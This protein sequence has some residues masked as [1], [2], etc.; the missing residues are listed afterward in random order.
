MLSAAATC[1]AIERSVDQC[2]R[3]SEFKRL[4]IVTGADSARRRSAP[5]IDDTSR[6]VIVHPAGG[7]G[8]D[9]SGYRGVT[10]RRCLR[11]LS[12]TPSHLQRDAL[13][14]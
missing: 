11:D 1:D 10:V 14:R 13:A 9:C 8:I 6:R 2:V 12:R 5:I 3:R 7:P 4:P